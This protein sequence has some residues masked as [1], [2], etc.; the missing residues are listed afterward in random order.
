ML[1]N[2]IY[3]P[4]TPVHCRND[5]YKHQIQMDPPSILA[6]LLFTCQV[7]ELGLPPKLV[8]IHHSSFQIHLLCLRDNGSPTR[9][10]CLQ[11]QSNLRK[12]TL[13]TLI[14]FVENRIRRSHARTDYNNL[15]ALWLL[16]SIP[17]METE[18]I[19]SVYPSNPRSI[20]GI[21]I[22]N[23]KPRH[24]VLVIYHRRPTSDHLRQLE[25]HLLIRHHHEI[26][27]N[28]EVVHH[29]GLLHRNLNVRGFLPV[30]G[31]AEVLQVRLLDDVVA[32]SEEIA[33]NRVHFG[34]GDHCGIELA[35]EVVT[36]HGG[37]IAGGGDSHVSEH[38][39]SVEEEKPRDSRV[40]VKLADGFGED[41][42]TQSFFLD[43]T[44]RFG[45]SA[46]VAGGAVF[47]LDGVDH[48]VAVEEVVAGDG[49][50]ER[51]GSV[52]DV[53]TLNAFGDFSGDR[54]GVG[55]GLL[56]HR[57]EVSGDL[58]TWVGGLGKWVLTL[59]GN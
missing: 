46:G 28:G 15:V 12:H 2:S 56:R 45:E 6:L 32:E 37:D 52:A 5:E 18:A 58:D 26:F 48:A 24:L 55:D 3:L 40:A 9:F 41:G 54:E 23:P 16:P 20:I 10:P 1:I 8:P 19:R 25:H 53:D 22:Q 50:V 21:L 49:L 31:E 14:A 30:R 47:E 11:I 34:V 51:V 43:E 36:T 27:G 17:E 29:G 42:A 57:S 4:N 44:L 13:Q 38:S 33:G 39:A 7:S 59:V 35:V